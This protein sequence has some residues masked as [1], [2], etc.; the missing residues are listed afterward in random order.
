MSNET[1]AQSPALLARPDCA[2]LQ[3]LDWAQPW[4]A[5]F[6]QPYGLPLTQ[7]VLM[8][9]QPVHQALNQ[10]AHPE[11]VATASGAD[12]AIMGHSPQTMRFN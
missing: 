7:A 12:A 1:P 10:V 2:A 9:G 8:Q 11:L 6:A 5:P 4:L 3:R